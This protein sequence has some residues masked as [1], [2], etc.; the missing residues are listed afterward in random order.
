MDPATAVISAAAPPVATELL[1]DTATS[2]DNNRE[3]WIKIGGV[4]LAVYILSIYLKKQ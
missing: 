1:K 3:K 4:L 2:S